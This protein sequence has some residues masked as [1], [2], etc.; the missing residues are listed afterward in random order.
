MVPVVLVGSAAEARAGNADIAETV[1]LV[2]PIIE[3]M[4]R[5]SRNFG[6]SG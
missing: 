2:V 1:V 4:A 3:G 5:G 6:V